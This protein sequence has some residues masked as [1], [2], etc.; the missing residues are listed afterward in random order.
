MCSFSLESTLDAVFTFFCPV[1]SADVHNIVIMFFLQRVQYG[2]K[3]RDSDAN[4]SS[5]A[6]ARDD[7]RKKLSSAGLSGDVQPTQGVFSVLCCKL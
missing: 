7:G 6:A 5:L 2:I 1:T 4:V 3:K